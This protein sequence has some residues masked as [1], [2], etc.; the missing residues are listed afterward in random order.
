VNL[1]RR[2][3]IAVTG[4]AALLTAGGGAMSRSSTALT[5]FIPAARNAR[6]YVIPSD[7]P[8]DNGSLVLTTRWYGEELNSVLENRGAVPVAVKEIVVW[9][10][11][12]RFPSVTEIYGE[13]FTMLSTT[14][15]TLAAPVWEHYRDA[16]HYRIPEPAS[17]LTAYGVA[18]LT[19]PEG[20]RVLI[21][22]LSSNR[23]VG[24]IS[25]WPDRLRVAFDAEDL[26]IAPGERWALDPIVVMTG[27]EG[28]TVLSEFAGRVS[29]LNMARAGAPLHTGWSSWNALGADLHF[30]QVLDNAQLVTTRA[31]MLDYVQIDDGYQAAMGDWFETRPGFGGSMADLC[32]AI[33]R[34][35]K[36][37]AVWVAPLIA[38]RNSNVFRDHP[39]WF[40]KDSGRQPLSAD[41][42]TFAGWRNGPWYGIDGSHPGAC[43]HL[44]QV[45]RRMRGEWGVD[46]F[47][48]DALF[49]GAMPGGFF[50][51]PRVSR[52]EAYRSALAA[53]RRGAGD[54]FITVANAPLWPT[55][56]FADASRASNDVHGSWSSF[57]QVGR[58]NLRR[59]WMHR[60]LWVT[61]PDSIMLGGD[62]TMGEFRAHWT[63]VYISGGIFLI[64][65]DLT[66]TP[67]ERVDVLRRLGHPTG[68]RPRVADG[69]LEL[70]TTDGGP[71]AVFNWG[72]EPKAVRLAGSPR[73]RWRDFWTSREFVLDGKGFAPAQ[74]AS[75]DAL[76]LHRL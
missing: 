17:A 30:G 49:W 16:I 6:G 3:A 24:T 26:V 14:S 55:V 28:G 64:G 69:Q 29:R 74:V 32:A 37:P 46:Y 23:F 50:H 43:D 2:D 25:V 21:G 66:R 54:A 39:E 31:P 53:I 11:A 1:T 12:H 60:R 58:Q 75:R 10:V 72:D 34:L 63:S 4:S 42:V 40:I 7:A 22:I 45:F 57:K 18:L 20:D 19:P 62:A 65:D 15:G 70:V 47:K 33:A 56:G 5:R 52:V 73:S 67:P 9:D 51:N 48:L 76:L 35:G 13:G 38:E 61:D 71:M 68:F 44:E 36:K 27:A 8:A 41:K 59:S